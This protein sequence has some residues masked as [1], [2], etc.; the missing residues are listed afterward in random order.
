VSPSPYPDSASCQIYA[1]GSL[2][3][4]RERP[5]EERRVHVRLMPRSGIGGDLL[6]PHLYA[7]IAGCL[8][9]GSSAT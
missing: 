1:G 5:R 7:L 2:P 9:T 6:P 8:S 3:W 4:E